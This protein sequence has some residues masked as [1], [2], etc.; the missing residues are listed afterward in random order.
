MGR[1]DP[2]GALSP[3]PCPI[4]LASNGI[5]PGVLGRFLWPGTKTLPGRSGEADN[6]GG[7]GGIL[8]S[9]GCNGGEG[10]PEL[11]GELVDSWPGGLAGFKTGP[12]LAGG[13]RVGW[14]QG[15]AKVR[16]YRT[17]YR[18]PRVRYY[19]TE[20]RMLNRNTAIPLYFSGKIFNTATAKAVYRGAVFG[21]TVPLPTLGLG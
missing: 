9:C 12:G 7:S 1:L 3:D 15:S 19:R 6:V 11:T 17:A 13:K 21:I 14:N 4:Q 2:I 18:K 8:N 5:P 20:Y 16:Y 10:P